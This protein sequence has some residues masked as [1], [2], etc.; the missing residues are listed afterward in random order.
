MQEKSKN[1][2]IIVALDGI[3]SLYSGV[4]VIVN[5]IFRGYDEICK[6]LD[7]DEKPDLYAIVPSFD[8]DS[9]FYN[10]NVYLSTEKV[11]KSH[12][13]K[14][15]FLPSLCH[16]ESIN[17]IWSGNSIFDT[18]L[19][20]ES[21]SVSLASQ[22]AVF[23][24]M[25]SGQII[26]QTHDTLF[27]GTCK[28]V[29]SNR[30]QI[31]WVPHSL[32]LVFKDKRHDARIDFET[33]AIENIVAKRGSI[34]FI[35]EQTKGLLENCF[36]VP[37]E[38]LISF[39]SGIIYNK[40]DEK[41]EEEL[42]KGLF[43]KYGIPDNKYL[44]FSW[45][46]CVY[47][48]GIDLIIDGF[49][50]LQERQKNNFHLVLLCPTETT[51]TEYLEEVECLLKTLNKESYT[52]ISEYSSQLP[53]IVLG[54]QKTKVIVL[55]SRFEGFGLISLET[56]AYKR[57]QSIVLYSPLDTFKEVLGDYEQAIKLEDFSSQSIAKCLDKIVDELTSEEHSLNLGDPKQYLAS[58]DF[59]KNYTKGFNELIHFF[60]PDKSNYR[61][62]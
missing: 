5:S 28:Y 1:V 30:V 52:F 17:V 9:T 13:G 43:S 39:Y 60:L 35:S 37:K 61:A 55:A 56:L 49:A 23:E 45:G 11:C 14:V 4:G 3:A 7:F 18:K 16:G 48:K 22:L 58:Y 10:E 41:E 53:P 47:Q 57:P 34:G 19:Q 29:D 24:K 38:R 44:I 32:S 27:A 31:C 40:I 21:L 6:N 20:W 12:G 46:R 8:F 36:N 15:I 2:L 59:V 51:P 25:Y 26:V 33:Q 62:K 50:K 42:R 54:Y